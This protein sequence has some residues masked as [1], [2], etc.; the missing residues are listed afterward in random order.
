MTRKRSVATSLSIL[1]AGAALSPA[2]C[3][4]APKGEDRAAFADE[5]QLAVRYFEREFPGLRAQINN[6]AG[7]AVFPGIAQWG[8]V[9][10]GGRHGRGM[11]NTPNDTQVGWSFVNTGSI[12]LQ[13]G[14]Q[15]FKMLVVFQDEDVFRRFK[16]GNLTG[17]AAAVAVAGDAGGS[18]AAPFVNGVAVY[19]GANSGLMAGVNLGLDYL[20]YEPLNE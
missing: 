5:A 1:L 3:S 19:Q 4:T 17:S 18:A 14:V 20:S 8:V 13:A 2:G 16:D 6:S 11:V 15:G 9:I 10:L 12:G 7:Y